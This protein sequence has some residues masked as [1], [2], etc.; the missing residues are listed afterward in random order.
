MKKKALILGVTGQDGSFLA[1]L[2]LSKGYQVHGL[3]RRSSTGNTVNIEHILDKIQVQSGD[4]SDATS[5]YRIIKDSRP[6]EIYNEADQDHAGWS[7]HAVDYASDI[8]GAAVGRILEIIRQINGKIRFFQPLTSNM[9]GK[10]NI[11]PQN[12][13]TPLRPQSPYAAAKVYAWML[14]RYYR[15]V[16][17]MFAACAILYNHESSRRTDSYVS[18]K[19]VK[20]AVNISKGLQKS[21]VLGEVDTPIDFGFAGDYVAAIWQIMQLPRA[22]DFVI[23]TGEAHTV[24]E[25]TEETFRLVGLDAG[26]YVTFDKKLVRPGKTSPLIADISKAKKAFGFTPAVRFKALVRLLVEDELNNE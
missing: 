15:D 25:F 22:D 13:E 16:H 11:C 24:R 2:L 17:G 19:I 8:T 21:L 12:E 20:A 18:R 26:K 3:V 4:L 10:T 9:F 1:E 7:Y 6:D 14:S 5:L 23:G